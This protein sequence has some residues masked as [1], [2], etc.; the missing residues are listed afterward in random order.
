MEFWKLSELSQFSVAV[1]GTEG[2]FWHQ[3][4]LDV[5]RNEILHILLALRGPNAALNQLQPLGQAQALVRRARV[6]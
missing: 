2:H 1:P 3:R 4:P 6:T 5:H